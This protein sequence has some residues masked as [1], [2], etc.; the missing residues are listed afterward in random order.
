MTGNEDLKLKFITE[1]TDH[2]KVLEE[3]ILHER[4]A[5]YQNNFNK[6]AEGLSQIK[7][8]PTFAIGDRSRGRQST[9]GSFRGGTSSGRGCG[10]TNLPNRN[11]VCQNCGACGL[12]KTDRSAR[13]IDSKHMCHADCRWDDCNCASATCPRRSSLCAT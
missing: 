3:V 11:N 9:R 1:K 5:V 2:K 6:L 7:A 13:K 4:G 12:P 8:E 10:R